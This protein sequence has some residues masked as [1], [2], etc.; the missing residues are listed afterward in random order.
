M[1]SILEPPKF[2]QQLTLHWVA[3]TALVVR[4][5]GKAQLIEN[6]VSRSFRITHH[7]LEGSFAFLLL[8]I[9][10]LFRLQGFSLGCLDFLFDS[11]FFLF[12]ATFVCEC[13]LPI[14]VVDRLIIEVAELRHSD[15]HLSSVI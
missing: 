2:Q 8:A 5:T 3:V 9:V 14:V 10:L 7:L 15:R 11:L 1:E 13:Q 6:F 12:A 4:L